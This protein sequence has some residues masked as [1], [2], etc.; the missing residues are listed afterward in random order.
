MP[1]TRAGPIASANRAGSA[2]GCGARPGSWVMTVSTGSSVTGARPST[3]ARVLTL[4][5]RSA[6]RTKW[7]IRNRSANVRQFAAK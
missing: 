7:K 3:T 4:A 6:N 2:G 5:F 1:L